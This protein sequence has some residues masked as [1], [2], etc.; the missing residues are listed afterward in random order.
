MALPF[1][2]I[3]A[4]GLGAAAV[5]AVCVLFLSRLIKK[6]R[7]ATRGDRA[8][9]GVQAAALFVGIEGAAEWNALAPREAG[10][11]SALV[12]SVVQRAADRLGGYV[13]GEYP[14]GG[15]VLLMH[16]DAQQ[17]LVLAVEL[18]TA[19]LKVNWAKRAGALAEHPALATVQTLDE[20]VCFSGPR[21]RVGVHYGP[22][23]PECREDG[24]WHYQGA[25]LCAASRIEGLACGGQVLCS[26]AV[27]ERASAV[28]CGPEFRVRDV[29]TCDLQG[30]LEAMTLYS[31]LP[32][33]LRARDAHFP[34]HPAPPPLLGEIARRY[35]DNALQC[36]SLVGELSDAAACV[37]RPLPAAAP[38]SGAARRLR[39]ELLEARLAAR[40]LLGA[41][42]RLLRET[43]V[44]PPDLAGAAS[45]QRQDRGPPALSG[46]WQKAAKGAAVAR[47]M[48]PPAREEPPAALAPVLL[49]TVADAAG[50][51][52]TG[53]CVR[54]TVSAPGCTPQTTRE[55]Q[56]AERLGWPEALELRLP[57]SSAPSAPLTL[58][59][60]DC[61]SGE[62]LGTSAV[63]AVFEELQRAP[64]PLMLTIPGG[65]DA[66]ATV[67]TLLVGA[68][69][70]P[71]GMPDG[72]ELRGS[73]TRC[74]GVYLRLP[75]ARVN[76][77]P[78]WRR[79]PSVAPDDPGVADRGGYL[80]SDGGGRW[81][82]HDA[83]EC[84]CGSGVGTLSTVQ[85]HGGALPTAHGSAWRRWE[86]SGFGDAVTGVQAVD[87][88]ARP[89][90][91]RLAAPGA[92]RREGLYAALPDAVSAN[93]LPVWQREGGGQW[94]YSSPGGKWFFS[95][96]PEFLGDSGGAGVAALDGARVRGGPLGLRHP[97]D[98]GGRRGGRPTADRSPRRGQPRRAAPTAP[99]Q[100]AAPPRFRRG[101]CAAAAQRRQ[102]RQPPHLRRQR[103]QAGHSTY[104]VLVAGAP[105]RAQPAIPR[106]CRPRSLSTVMW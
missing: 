70:E 39:D 27:L 53:G 5:L 80:F 95:D 29:G 62:S 8:P 26:H 74:D 97:R 86:L 98:P 49:V 23:A 24:R 9:R 46:A 78:V 17:A 103:A 34:R 51:P 81:V 69:R 3:V 55:R 90:L 35:R 92:L 64:Q 85:P 67:V 42:Q 59:I 20:G 76:G 10:A 93:G 102:P 89:A 101:Q 57:P 44:A 13:V 48:K 16:S 41:Y 36:E 87:C 54:C 21:L 52:P 65:G 19:L 99:E 60:I 45:P 68:H 4:V 18:Q 47:L 28:R 22:V 100:C 91:L 32:L 43:G 77:L 71:P 7:D 105:L 75:G 37:G 11:L 25:G 104:P 88:G 94:L 73:G 84:T 6:R 58:Q 61:A 56:W 82:A 1:A 63:D 96:R 83:I 40:Y 30:G 15:G 12:L 72:V 66:Q 33:S 31:V 79:Q 106:D 14:G 38:V 2:A 50:V